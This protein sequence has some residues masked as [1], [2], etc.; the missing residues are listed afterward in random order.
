MK[1]RVGPRTKKIGRAVGALVGLVVVVMLARAV[2]AK[3]KQ[4]AVDAA[5]TE[6]TAPE[7]AIDAEACA[8]HLA[9]AVRVKTISTPEETAPEI[10]TLRDQVLP[11]LYPKVH[12][13][14]TREVIGH[15]VLY[16]WKGKNPSAEPVVLIA[17]MDVVPVD[18]GSLGAWTHPPFDGTVAEKFIWGRGTLDDKIGVIGLLEAAEA[19]LKEGWAPE[20]TIMLG[21]GSD[22]EIGGPHGAEKIAEA[23]AARGVHARLL[24]DEGGAVTKGIVPNVAAPVAVIGIAEKGYLTVDLSI[25]GLGGHSSSPPHETAITIL[26]GAVKRLFDTPM[27]AQMDGPTATFLA[28]IAPEMSFGPRFLMTNMWLTRPLVERALSGS[29]AANAS[30]RTTTA[31]TIFHAGTTADNV[32]PATGTATINFRIVPG[33]TSD[34]VIAHV[35]DVVGDPRIEIKARENTRKE[36]S[37]ISPVDGPELAAVARTVREVFPDAVVAPALTIGATDARKY[38][39]VTNAAYRF[40]P[41]E[42][43]AADLLRL[44][45]TNE[46]IGV[47]AFAKSV[48][49]YRRLMIATTAP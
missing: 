41:V 44:H 3:S 25:G 23:L 32:L 5:A 35:K 34:S 20:R 24:V 13:A 16:T 22:E 31:P 27:P 7:K 42:M 36:P 6:L 2:M 39:K 14:M 38:Y 12:A 9:A 28:W 49:F 45:G 21:F 26:A 4:P 29:P 46:R 11:A 48:R 47:D 37:A 17:H 15:G 30:I 19:L 8:N 43:D 18:D 40:S 1:R 10:E 33:D